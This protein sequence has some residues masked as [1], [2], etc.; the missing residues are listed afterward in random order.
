[1]GTV[2]APSITVTDAP[3]HAQRFRLSMTSTPDGLLTTGRVYQPVTAMKTSR[4]HGRKLFADRHRQIR[5]RWAKKMNRM[6]TT[7]DWPKIVLT[8]AKA[9]LPE[10]RLYR[11]LV[12]SGNAV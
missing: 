10:V 9:S 12:T 7:D 6:F 8:G 3:R 1:M 11:R 4:P 2:N 5:I